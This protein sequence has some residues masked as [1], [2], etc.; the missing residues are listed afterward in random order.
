MAITA[1]ANL[2]QTIVAQ[3][4]KKYYLVSAD[5]KNTGIWAQFVDWQPPIPEDGGGGSSFDFPVYGDSYDPVE[6]ALTETADVTPT[7]ID[8]SN[9]TV[10]PYEYGFTGGITKLARWQSRVNQPAIHGELIAKHRIR[11]IDRIIRRGACGRGASYP[12]Q[13]M[14]VDASVAMSALTYTDIPTWAWLTELV[15]HANSQGVEPMDGTNFVSVIH[16]LM[17]WELEQMN[18]WK[19]PGYYQ[20]PDNLYKGEVGMMAGIRFITS[21]LGRVYLGSGTTAAGAASTV[22]GAHA[23][24]ATTLNVA[25]ASTLGAAVGL[26]VTVGTLETES[27][28]PGAN[29]EQVKITAVNTNALTIQSLG[30]K[31]DLGLRYDHASG[32]AVNIAYNVCALP[33][34][35]KNSL[36]GVY[37]SSTGQYG[38]AVAKTGMDLLN[39]FVYMGWY[40]YGG[41]GLIQ[42]NLLL[43]KCGVSK[44]IKGTN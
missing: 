17:Q 9:V 24:G 25:S 16:P 10:T 43:G 15:M 22:D 44:F 34:I 12:T 6:S 18:E 8:D 20:T 5:P 23:K 38:Q 40:W 27:V 36:I 31:G 3:Y 1:V 39:R 19:Y 4:E 13:T 30:P 2:D 11:S 41:I 28:N 14:H 33:L 37:G 35:G 32:E 21:P 42:R 7:Y 29:L 26:Y